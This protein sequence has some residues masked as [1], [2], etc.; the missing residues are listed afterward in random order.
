MRYR[1][2]DIDIIIRRS[3]IYGIL[4]GVLASI[5]LLFGVLAGQMLMVRYPRYA[6]AIQIFA[7][8]IPVILYTPT[9]RWIGM[10]VDRIFFKIQYNYAQALVAFQEAV[11][12]ASSQEEIA[13]LTQRFI[14]GE[15]R[16]QHAAVLARRGEA[17]EAAG[18]LDTSAEDVLME[19]YKQKA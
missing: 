18:D 6:G 16:L 7:V 13:D 15:L 1:F 4:A 12:V 17:L 14:K 2:L 19:A 10:W 9:R 8:A 11:R 3:L 5:Y